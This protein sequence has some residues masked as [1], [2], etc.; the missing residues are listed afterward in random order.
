MSFAAEMI[1][2]D[3]FTRPVT[4]HE[5]LTMPLSTL[6]TASNNQKNNTVATTNNANTVA[7]LKN[8]KNSLRITTDLVEKPDKYVVTA[9]LPGFKKDQIKLSVEEGVLTIEGHKTEHHT[10]KDS[11]YI[12]RERSY[13]HSKRSIRLPQD[14]DGY[15]Y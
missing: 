14:T 5:L 6:A 9:E 7:S 15:Q 8:S 1:F 13:G 2:A 12:H 4:V 10:E 3:P 11:S